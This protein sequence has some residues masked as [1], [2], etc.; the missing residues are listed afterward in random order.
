MSELLKSPFFVLAIGL[1]SIGLAKAC[2]YLS[3]RVPWLRER[4]KPFM[5][6]ALTLSMVLLA[7][8]GQ[9]PLRYALN[10]VLAEYRDEVPDHSPPQ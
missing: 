2:D 1:F 10:D 5:I 7:S 6:G 3:K 4:R 8:L 9:I